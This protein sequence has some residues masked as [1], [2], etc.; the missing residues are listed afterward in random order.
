MSEGQRVAAIEGWFSLE[1]PPHAPPSRP[2]RRFEDMTLAERRAHY[3]YKGDP[4]V[5]G[6]TTP[7]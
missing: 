1:D 7:N 2:Y 3:G 5:N 6:T 4:S